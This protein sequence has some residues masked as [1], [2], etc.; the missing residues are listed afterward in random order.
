MIMQRYGL[1]RTNASRQLTRYILPMMTRDDDKIDDDE[2]ITAATRNNG[3]ADAVDNDAQEKENVDAS[4]SRDPMVPPK[5]P[6][7]P[8]RSIVIAGVT[9]RAGRALL[10]YY[11]RRGHIVAGCGRDEKEVES[12]RASHPGAML[13]VVNIMDDRD[14]GLWAAALEEAGT[15]F[16]LVIAADAISLE[17]PLGVVPTAAWE[18]PAMDFN[19]MIDVNVKG[20]ANVMRHLV[21]RMIRDNT[22]DHGVGKA[23][24]S[25]VAGSEK[26]GAFVALSSAF[27]RTPHPGRAAYC[28]SKFAIEGMVKSLAMSL[29]VPMCAV[30][31]AP[32]NLAEEAADAHEKLQ[33]A[34]AEAR[35]RNVMDKWVTKAGPMILG[36][37]RKDN[38]KSKSVVGYYSVRERQAWVIPDGTS[39]PRKRSHRT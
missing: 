30:P 35:M 34:D 36:L 13:D 29:P 5:Q 21:P 28:A 31:L 11:F 24:G 32:G 19:Y 27:G 22:G 12:L 8:P 4:A 18:V 9:S 23:T 14:V 26:G 10:G 39:I 16:D 33:D 3:L 38:G 25:E 2:P 17:A 20:V 7:K 15:R 1:G 6:Q 37:R